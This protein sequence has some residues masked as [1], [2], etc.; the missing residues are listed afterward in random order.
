MEEEERECVRNLHLLYVKV[1]SQQRGVVLVAAQV[2]PTGCLVCLHV[3]RR[4]LGGV[5]VTRNA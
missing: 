2:T 3:A 1:E 4:D 5:A